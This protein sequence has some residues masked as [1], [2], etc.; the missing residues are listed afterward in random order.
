LKLDDV[1]SGK[2]G[3]ADLPDD[4]SYYYKMQ[5]FVKDKSVKDDNNLYI[6]FLCSF[7]GKGKEFINVDLGKKKPAEEDLKKL[8]KIY[9][10]LTKPNQEVDLNVEAVQVAGKQPVFFVVDTELT[11]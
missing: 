7:E 3:K 11:I 10:I 2:K 5:L 1:F 6:L 9:K 8:K 4:M